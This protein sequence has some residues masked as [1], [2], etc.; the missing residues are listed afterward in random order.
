[1]RFLSRIVPVLLTFSALALAQTTSGS[2]AGSVVDQA[3][4]PVV[5]AAVTIRNQDTNALFEAKTRVAGDF[6]VT[7]LQAAPYS[8]T[9]E[10]PGFKKFEKTNVVLTSN[11]NIS[12]GQIELQVG[13]L[14]QSVEVVAQGAQLQAET[15]EQ[16]T[17]LVGTQIENTMVNGRSPL[18]LLAL[19]PGMY[20]DGDFSVVN[21]QTGNI[22]TNGTRGTTFNITLNGISNIDTGSNTKMMSTVSMDA[23]AEVHVMTA[24]FDAQYGKNSGGQIMMITKGG[25]K[26]FH[27]AG[28]W[29]YRDRGLNANTWMNNRENVMKP[30]YHYNYEGYNIGGPAFI[31]G[32]FNRDRDKLFFFWSE[33]YQQQLIPQSS[34][35]HVT[36]PTA[37]ERQ[38]NFSQ[39]LANNNPATPYTPKD[40]TTGAP[41]PGGIIP[42]SRLYAPGLALL[43]LYPLP[44][45]TGQNGFNYQS[46]V[47]AS[48]P[49]HEQ[50][51]RMDY[52]ATDK[53][54]FFGSLSH[55]A[56]DVLT[57]DYCPSGYSLCPNFPLTPI[58]YNHPGY[59]LSLNAT[60]TIS[61]TMVNETIFGIAHHP[62][63]VM[64]EDANALTTAATGVNL[65]TLY[66][67]Y[68]NWIPRISFNG[69]R[70]SNAP[71][72]D[73]GGGEW[74]PFNT[75]NSTIEFDDNLS[76]IFDKHALKAGVFIHRN[77]KNQS[78]YA[79][80]EGHYD[81][82]DNSANP[83]DTGYGFANAAIGTFYSFTDA[84]QY[85]TGE[86]RY[87]NAEFY[88]QDSWKMNRRLTV[89]YGVRAY[90]IQPY[91]D[92]GQ[93]TSNFLPNLYNPSQAVRLYWPAIVNG[94]KVGLD[95]A[96][97]QTVSSFLI[98]QIVPGSGNLADG[99]A[100]AGHGISKYLMKS[101]GILMAPRAGL[102]WDIT[103]KQN[104]VFRAGAGVYYD[105]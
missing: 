95:R 10:Q 12:I 79:K 103:G 1:M 77:R 72:F 24:N 74:S 81:W 47:S 73:T 86:Y 40:Y 69:T 29:Y 60:R 19:V 88:V 42:S 17:S 75:Y 26:D 31:P 27:G 15:A 104:F 5:G 105:R 49:R 100:Q 56:K 80:T 37:L 57:S 14:Q 44:N 76:K 41:F 23:V 22:Y 59:V 84:S 43:N 87:T 78:A 21:N 16:S 6:V 46:Q 48:E 13:S 61:P 52:N 97:G 89:N 98:G 101:P 38:G 7:N 64:P 66:P 91:Y 53:W 11:T 85:V 45:V 32:K 92:A 83:Y 2:I 50:L 28:F 30:Y 68:D 99:L 35:V 62:V 70:I 39:T 93:D 18:A 58:Q 65:P 4:A 82:G 94:S 3:G 36:V 90:W 20:T 8:V 25:S 51:I 67:P 54:R 34:A 55:L 71:S 9:V 33:E 102:A 96:T 63:T